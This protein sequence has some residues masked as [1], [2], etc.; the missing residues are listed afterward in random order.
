[1][2]TQVALFVVA[3]VTVA[4]FGLLV[5]NLANASKLQSVRAS[6]WLR[7]A[8]ECTVV[9]EC[10]METGTAD[11]TDVVF[12]VGITPITMETTIT[13]AV[14]I[15]CGTVTSSFA[16]IRPVTFT[17]RIDAGMLADKSLQ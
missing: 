11:G 12:T 6:C 10:I 16:T 14:R 15:A 13:P 1:M 17:T 4:A 9:A 7:V 5:S 8:V 2:R 3:L